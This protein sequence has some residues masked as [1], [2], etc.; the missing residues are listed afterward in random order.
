MAVIWCNGNW[1][2][3][4]GLPVAD[5]GWTL[6]LSLFETILAIDGRAVFAERHL[7]RLRV[8]CGRWGWTLPETEFPSL[9]PGLLEKRGLA[10]GR[11]R[12]RLTVTGGSGTSGDLA[13]GDD[14]LV[15]LAAAPC[16]GPP[17]DVAVLVSP[18]LRNERSPLA[19]L[20]CGSY[21]ENV[22]AL[23]HARRLG[24]GETL[25]FNTAGHL[26][27]AAMANV[28]L[29]RGGK[30]LTPP[31]TAGCLP[32]ITRGVILELAGAEEAEISPG[33]LDAAEEVFLTSATRGPVGVSRIGE[34]V[35]QTGTIT[36]QVADIWNAAVSA[37]ATPDTLRK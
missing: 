36:G 6:G 14:R 11:A 17:A 2:E 34:R 9:M 5:R 3:A 27:E 4:G 19:G 37:L 24:F 23:D 31:L 10:A 1:V 12:L 30:L 26:C 15:W 35:L 16:E 8:A 22:A 21:A 7:A 13:G 32:G 28:F 33:D 20:K 18:W 25:F 29:V